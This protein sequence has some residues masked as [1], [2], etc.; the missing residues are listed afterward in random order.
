M[1]NREKFESLN[2]KKL[3][4]TIPRS[5]LASGFYLVLPDTDVNVPSVHYIDHSGR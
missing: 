5:L 3:F 4:E 2:A 1:L